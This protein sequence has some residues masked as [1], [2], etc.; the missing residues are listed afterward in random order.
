MK[1]VGLL[2]LAL[3]AGCTTTLAHMEPLATAGQDVEYANGTPTVLSRGARF[4]V[5][6]SPRCGVTGRYEMGP[7]VELMIGVRN[8]SDRRVEVS[9]SNISATGNDAPAPVLKAAAIE[10]SILRSAAWAHAMNAVGGAL[11]SAA[12]SLSA[13]TKTYSASGYVGGTPVNV[14][15]TVHDQDAARQAQREVVAETVANARA[16]DAR[17]SADLGQVATL[18]QRNTIRPGESYIGIA[19]IEPPRDTACAIRETG[20]NGNLLVHDGPCKLKISIDVDG[21]A[22]TF[23]F[24]EVSGDSEPAERAEQTATQAPEPAEQTETRSAAAPRS[25]WE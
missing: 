25:R 9:E 23:N 7:R 6:L 18:F 21:E 10:D 22:H 14:S 11:N 3:V 5:A 16:I 12:A 13:G 2:S 20:A 4:D 15:G 1:R 24:N 17:K 8:R 19:I